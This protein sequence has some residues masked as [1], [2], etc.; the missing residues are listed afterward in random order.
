MTGY[1]LNY[2]PDFGV[3]YSIDEI[4]IRQYKEQLEKYIVLINK[5][6]VE[7][8]IETGEKYKEEYELLFT[9]LKSGIDSRGK[10]KV[11]KSSNRKIA[12]A[13]SRSMKNAINDIPTQ[14]PELANHLATTIKMGALSKYEPNISI[15]WILY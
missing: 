9:E 13:V 3:H 7:G 12:Q 11:D 14:Y 8:D 5:A 1:S 10:P 6:S 2:C 15:D 4:A